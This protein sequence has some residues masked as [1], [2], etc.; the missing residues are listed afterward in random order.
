MTVTYLSIR[1]SLMVVLMCIRDFADAT[2]GWMR[3]SADF[4]VQLAPSGANCAP[5]AP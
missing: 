4:P 3:E 2:N 1:R 5:F